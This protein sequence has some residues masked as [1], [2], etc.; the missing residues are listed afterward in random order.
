MAAFATGIYV[1]DSFHSCGKIRKAVVSKITMDNQL[2]TGKQQ[3][4]QNP[5]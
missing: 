2:I 4:I 3:F 1:G 5:Y